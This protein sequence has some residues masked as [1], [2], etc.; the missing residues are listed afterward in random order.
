M[1]TDIQALWWEQARSDHEVFVLLRKEG[2]AAC[3]LL[4]Y[5]Q[6][7]TEKLAKAYS[8]REGH[9]PRPSH[10]SFVRFLKKLDVRGRSDRQRIAAGLGF[11]GADGFQAFIRSS[12]PLAYEIERL[13]PDLAGFDA[14]NPEYPWPHRSPA[15]APASFPFDVWKQIERN[16]RGHQ[17]ISV[18]DRLVA[19]FESYA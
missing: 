2:V 8:W 12:A 4:H 15:H 19:T 7:A 11:K 13:A 17:L 3:H 6:M 1:M 14:P 10:A 16:A 5:L 18:I 9:P